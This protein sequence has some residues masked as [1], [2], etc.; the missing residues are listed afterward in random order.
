MGYAAAVLCVVNIAYTGIVS[1][2]IVGLVLRYYCGGKLLFHS[3]CVHYNSYS[4]IVVLLVRKIHT[5]MRD[6]ALFL[7]SL[8]YHVVMLLLLL[9]MPFLMIVIILPLDKFGDNYIH[10]LF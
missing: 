1:T 8:Y 10:H 9:T 7:Y 2:F 6:I 5:A 3:F 4:E